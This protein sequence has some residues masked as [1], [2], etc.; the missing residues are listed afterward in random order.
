MIPDGGCL[1][2]GIGADVDVV[3]DLHGIV[4]E[5]ATVRL[6]RWSDRLIVEL[7]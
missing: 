3:P 4:V 2:D 7:M 1:D 6:V 5:V